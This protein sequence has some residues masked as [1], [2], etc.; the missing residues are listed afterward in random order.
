MDQNVRAPEPEPELE[1]PDS[2]KLIE[3]ES[4]K[5][6]RINWINREGYLMKAKVDLL[7]NLVIRD[8]EQSQKQVDYSMELARQLEYWVFKDS[9]KSGGYS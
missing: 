9:R 1:I 3:P 7:E 5:I 4:K 2:C 8:G 6:Q